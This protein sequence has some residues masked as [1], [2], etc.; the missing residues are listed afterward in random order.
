MIQLFF[1]L[2]A[3]NVAGNKLYT[4]L[5]ILGLVVGLSGS[6]IL[7]LWVNHEISYDR[8]HEDSERIYRVVREDYIEGVWIR[9]V[10]TPV[11]LAN[12][13]PKRY[14]GIIAGTSVWSEGQHTFSNDNSR[15]MANFHYCSENFFSVF[16]FPMVE[17]SGGSAFPHPNSV[18]ISKDFAMKMF[19]STDCLEEEIIRHFFGTTSYYISAV[20]DVPENSHF[21]FEVLVPYVS[22]Q[23]FSFA[24]SDWSLNAA[25]YF[26]LDK[27]AGLNGMQINEMK[28]ILQSKSNPTT[29][30][31]FQPLHDIYLFTDFD[32]GFSTKKSSY[33]FVRL[34]SVIAYA[35]LALSII[36]YIMLF[37]SRSEARGKEIAI[38]KLMG[39]GRVKLIALY[40]LEILLVTYVALFFSLLLV[41]L[42][43]PFLNGISGK[44]LKLIPGWE[45]GF[46]FLITGFSV[47]LLSA[48]Y[49]A[50]YLSRFSS[51][52]LL[53]GKSDFS[54]R[55]R[56]NTLV[57]ILQ[58][59]F[60]TGFVIFSLSLLAQFR[61]INKKEKGL[62]TTNVLAMS[63]RAF[64]YNYT[65]VKNKLL[66]HSNIL[67]V[68]A[69]G[70][71]PVDYQFSPVQQIRWEGM[72]LPADLDVTV[73]NVDPDYLKTF[74]IELIEGEFLPPDMNIE[75]HFDG[76]YMENTPVIINERFKNLMGM[77][78]PIGKTLYMSR[79]DANGIIKGV[80]KDFH[81]RP[82]TH[83]IEPLI[84]FYYPEGFT[85]MYI[86][87]G[88]A[89]L[90][91]TMIYINEVAN[92]FK[93]G[94]DIVFTFFLEDAIKAQYKEQFAV[95]H[96]VFAA[97]LAIIYL[98]IMGILGMV[99]Y[100]MVREKKVIT[101]R[102]IYGAD[103]MD[104]KLF[105][106]R[107][108]LMLFVWGYLPTIVISWYIVE[109]WLS[110]FAY[111]YNP[112]I[113]ISLAVLLA[114]LGMV[115]LLVI[116]SVNR[117]CSVNPADSIKKL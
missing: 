110:A 90:P 78:E 17:K 109:R 10:F 63:T 24:H 60:A 19:G 77:K 23:A 38:K 104:L 52:N 56:I 49:I 14:P 4:L 57:A 2:F 45:F 53:R 16:D 82:L 61:Y 74:Q 46:Y 7:F 99:S 95:N 85:H 36:N 108:T 6:Y 11:P 33:T 40:S 84:M 86:K 62:E 21:N 12:E 70:P 94:E 55:F 96:F 47:S 20:V 28:S 68:T 39:V 54:P 91:S 75:K 50:F 117:T 102:K 81:F 97:T 64:G 26:K 42:I 9:N 116:L 76:Y 100:N 79:F 106:I 1:K 88:E 113:S 15:L 80:V 22:S 25:N 29:R 18:V 103:T 48:S 41:N 73:M 101:I 44:T 67:N 111:V 34:T 66:A 69:G 71:P 3:R 112:F 65:F 72:E 32:D 13:L 58:L 107:K 92:E 27:K 37:T 31:S 93:R 105:Y 89:D 43:L 30:I 51:L 5:G 115:S 35:L 83:S 98:A 59:A 114:G 8:F 87:I